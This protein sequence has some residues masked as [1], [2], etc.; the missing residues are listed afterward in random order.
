MKLHYFVYI[1]WKFRIHLKELDDFFIFLCVLTNEYFSICLSNNFFLQKL[2]GNLHRE[3]G[4]QYVKPHKFVIFL[5]FR[6]HFTEIGWFL[7]F[8]CM[9]DHEYFVIRLSNDFYLQKLYG[10]LHRA[11]QEEYVMPH[12]FTLFLGIYDTFL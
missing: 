2:Y 11:C 1:F 9:L 6:S 8:T 3:L 7:N 12:F 4:K 5:T 10:T